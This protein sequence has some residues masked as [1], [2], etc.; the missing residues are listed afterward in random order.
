MMYFW[1]I[2]IETIGFLVGIHWLV[3]CVKA[4]AMDSFT[5]EV[6]L[7]KGVVILYTRDK[8]RVIS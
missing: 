8:G 1:N 3:Y 6:Y 5:S 7:R 2:S 4:K